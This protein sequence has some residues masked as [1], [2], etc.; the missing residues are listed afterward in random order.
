MNRGC[1]PARTSR[2]RLGDRF[3]LGAAAGPK[4]GRQAAPGRKLPLARDRFRPGRDA[5]NFVAK[6]DEWSVQCRYEDKRIR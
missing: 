1:D 3:T 4:L 6:A 5:H 2:K